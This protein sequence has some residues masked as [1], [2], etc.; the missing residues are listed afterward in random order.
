MRMRKKKHSAERIE[1]CAE[2]LLKNPIDC[3]EKED[4]IFGKKCPMLLE[5]GCG[6]GDFV[7]QLS[8]AEPDYNYIAMER[9]D[10]VIVVAANIQRCRKRQN[11]NI[12]EN[13]DIFNPIRY[14]S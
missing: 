7:C 14:L 6:K 1:A 12:S 11:E 3:F 2:L 5:I 13:S 9:V 8:K 4:E 10:D